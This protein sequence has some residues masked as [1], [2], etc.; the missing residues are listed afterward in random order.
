MRHFARGVPKAKEN[1]AMKY[2]LPRLVPEGCDDAA[3]GTDSVLLAVYAPF[4]TD[5][6][7]SSYPGTTQQPL[8][9]H[10]LVRNLLQVAGAGI[11]VSALIDRVGEN[12]YLVEIPA[13]QPGNM[14]ITS[15]WKEDMSSPLVLSGFLQRAHACHPKA[16][17]VLSLEG[18]G[19]GYLPEID[20]TQ[21]TVGNVTGGGK[22][23]WTISDEDSPILPTGSPVLP[24]GS[25]VLPTGSPVLPVNHMPLSTWGTGDALR[26]AQKCGVPKVALL[27]FNNCFNMSAE[28]LHT[29]APYAEYA[30][31]YINYNFFTSGETYPDVFRRLGRPG[32]H[33]TRELAGWF[34]LGNQKFLEAKGNHPTVGASVQLARMKGIADG[35]DTLARELLQ[36]LR[37]NPLESPARKAVADAIQA[38]I[39]AAQQYDTSSGG[40]FGLETPDELTDIGSFAITLQAPS[41]LPNAVRVAARA[42]SQLLTGI[43]RYGSNDLPWIDTSVRWDFKP[44]AKD[45]LAMN[46]LLPDPQRKGIWDWRS[47]YYMDINPDPNL[48]LV[49]PH[50]IDFLKETNWVEFID[51]YHKAVPF[52][53]LRAGRIPDFPIFNAKFV[54]PDK[55]PCDPDKPPPY[56]KP[57]ATRGRKGA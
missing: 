54:P 46:I 47:P 23:S 52:K 17:I 20:R 38:A 43:K 16:A 49:Q 48:P 12:T 27:H 42:L 25:P 34:A 21:L 29:V 7:L 26:R 39:E 56:G 3:A 35:I 41:A 14:R 24:T 13:G 51:E 11:H 8:T 31:G 6:T 55:P 36:A 33:T 57:D 50:V 40:G 9:Q 32:P 1:D 18:H 44:N 45:D 53:G 37:A 2:S 4:G 5:K 30:T 10:P 28:L 22:I 19:A 15:T